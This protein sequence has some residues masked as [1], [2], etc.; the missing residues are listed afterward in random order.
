MIVA[1]QGYL[2]AV[3]VRAGCRHVRAICRRA[4]GGPCPGTGK[5]L[6]SRALHGPGRRVAVFTVLASLA[7]ACPPV[8]G[9]GA[10]Q[11]LAAQTP[12][13]PG[14]TVGVEGQAFLRAT[15]DQAT[16]ERATGL[17][18]L[19]PVRAYVGLAGAPTPARRAEL[20]VAELNR[21][22]GFARSTILVVIPTGSGWVDPAAV[23]SL[24]LLTRG[25]LSTVVVQYADQP[26]WLE[27]LA[28]PDRATPAAQALTTALREQLDQIPAAHRPRLLIFGESLGAVAARSVQ[29]TAERALLVGRPGGSGAV[30]SDARVTAVAH[31]DD[32]VGWWSPELAVRRPDGWPGIWL[33]IITFWQVS[34]SLPGAVDAPI[35]HGHHYGVELV[36][37]WRMADPDGPAGTAPLP[38]VDAARQH[39]LPSPAGV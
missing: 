24:E 17:P 32:P 16:I 28:H 15:P 14:H 6:H 26:S 19:A 7:L 20:A 11:R 13:V 27:Y 8:D 22:G 3:A 2:A 25:D 18:A 4:S 36:D 5:S 23:R 35:G 38:L 21:S 10:Y 9:S 30:A 31:F 37:A 29:G 34:G 1:A 12:P 39:A 33:P